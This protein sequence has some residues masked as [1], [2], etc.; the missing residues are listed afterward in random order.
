LEIANATAKQR[1]YQSNRERVIEK[2]RQW[3]LANP[4][5]YRE[6][7]KDAKRR[8][9]LQ[10]NPLKQRKSAP[11]VMIELPKVVLFVPAPGY[12]SKLHGDYEDWCRRK[13]LDAKK[14]WIEETDEY[15]G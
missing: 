2:A 12:D 6:V 7:Q 10:L 15:F 3:R 5:R 11:I 4:E 1:W 13:G 8:R 14:S 9:R